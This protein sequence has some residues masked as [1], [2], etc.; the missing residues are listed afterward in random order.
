MM[1]MMPIL[2][3]YSSTFGQMGMAS[4]GMINIDRILIIV[5]NINNHWNL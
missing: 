5:G 2:P 4:M 3:I 1:K